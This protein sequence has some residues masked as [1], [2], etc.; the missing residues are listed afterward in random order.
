LE[1]GEREYSK[2]VEAEDSSSEELRSS[3]TPSKKMMAHKLLKVMDLARDFG[4]NQSLLENLGTT[5]MLQSTGRENIFT[6]KA[7]RK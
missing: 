4:G 5:R 7:R 3:S 6:M 2:V 1:Y